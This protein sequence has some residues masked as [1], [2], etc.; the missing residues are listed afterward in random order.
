MNYYHPILCKQHYPKEVNDAFSEGFD[1]LMMGD[2]TTLRESKSASIM[3]V[4]DQ[5]TR[6]T[7]IPYRSHRFVRMNGECWLGEC[8]GFKS[9][10]AF[11]VY[12]YLLWKRSKGIGKTVFGRE[13]IYINERVR[14][15]FDDGTYMTLKEWF[16]HTK[17]NK[18]NKVFEM[19][20]NVLGSVKKCWFDNSFIK[21]RIT[22]VAD[23]M[24]MVIKPG[25]DIVE[26]SAL[27]DEWVDALAHINNHCRKRFW[28]RLPFYRVGDPV[29]DNIG[30]RKAHCNVRSIV[31]NLVEPMFTAHHI[32][33][34]FTELKIKELCAL[35]EIRPYPDGGFNRQMLARVYVS[36]LLD[37][38]MAHL[39]RV[40]DE[41]NYN[42]LPK[43]FVDN[44][45][46]S[47]MVCINSEM[48]SFAGQKCLRSFLAFVAKHG[49][50]LKL[51]APKLAW[52]AKPVT[53]FVADTVHLEALH[54]IL[55]PHSRVVVTG[56]MINDLSKVNLFKLKGAELGDVFVNVNRPLEAAQELS[57]CTHKERTA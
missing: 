18:T 4:L 51:Q 39:K 40:E 41:S 36:P 2:S 25:I 22:H 38:G 31:Y 28:L 34:E 32:G 55:K 17:R 14:V 3:D 46:Y 15:A 11:I 9:T 56:I 37:A 24:I 20:S 35:F 50:A 29:L 13:F 8:F 12:T 19:Y 27:D 48:R 6:F 5:L 47:F 53:V 52:Y 43:L 7:N 23:S 49:G 33:E 30:P 44:T 54:E 21:G 42:V 45:P 26:L 16:V 57:R 10:T 1:L